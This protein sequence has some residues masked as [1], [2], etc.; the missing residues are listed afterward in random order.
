[1]DS[2]HVADQSHVQSLAGYTSPLFLSQARALKARMRPNPQHN[3]HERR[4]DFVHMLNCTLTATERTLCCILENHQ[5]PEGV[6][7]ATYY[8]RFPGKSS[9]KNR[10]RL[11]RFLLSKCCLWSFSTRKC[12]QEVSHLRELHSEI[13]KSQAGVDIFRGPHLSR[14]LKNFTGRNIL[15]LWAFC[16]SYYMACCRVPEALQQYMPNKLAFLPFRQWR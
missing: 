4:K 6:R 10:R 1:M 13:G 2:R 16:I 14:S 7:R 3:D 8:R 15:K 12:C 11:A 5:T 9:S